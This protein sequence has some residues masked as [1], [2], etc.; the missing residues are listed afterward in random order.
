[1]YVFLC[2]FI[3]LVSY[4]PPNDIRPYGLFKHFAIDFTILVLPTPGGP[5]NNNTLA[6]NIHQYLTS[7]LTF[8]FT[9]SNKL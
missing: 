1:M 9:N 2:P 8:Y 3:I 6:K 4:Y 7:E 5:C